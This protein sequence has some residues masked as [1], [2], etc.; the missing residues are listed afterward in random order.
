MTSILI[1]EDQLALLAV[2]GAFLADKGYVVSAVPTAAG[3]LKLLETRNIDVLL[4]DIVLPGEMNGFE[5]ARRA[6]AINPDVKVIYCTGE[7][8]LG[9]EQIGDAFGPLLTKPYTNGRLIALLEYVQTCCSAPGEDM[10]EP[11]RKLYGT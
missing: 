11:R 6:R 8:E 9:P 3:A 5:L 10:V 2:T 1:V 7:S 4:T